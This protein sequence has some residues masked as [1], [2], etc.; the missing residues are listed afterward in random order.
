MIYA[1]MLRQKIYK[2][3]MK[4]DFTRQTFANEEKNIFAGQTWTKASLA[5]VSL[6][7]KISKGHGTL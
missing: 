6:T 2:F 3:Q 5:K 4:N 1:G 7:K